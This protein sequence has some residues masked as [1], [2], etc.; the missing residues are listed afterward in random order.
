MTIKFTSNFMLLSDIEKQTLMYVQ[1]NFS[2]ISLKTMKSE[3]KFLTVVPFPEMV[4]F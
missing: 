2:R 3:S 4:Y 1:L